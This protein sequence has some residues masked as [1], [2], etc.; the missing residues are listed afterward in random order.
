MQNYVSLMAFNTANKIAK[1]II[2]LRRYDQDEVYK[3]KCKQPKKKLF[4][5]RPNVCAHY[6]IHILTFLSVIALFL[7]DILVVV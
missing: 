3:K 6:Y 1:K 4:I 5:K 7:Y 2:I